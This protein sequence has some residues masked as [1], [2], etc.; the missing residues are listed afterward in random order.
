[1][2]MFRGLLPETPDEVLRLVLEDRY[3]WVRFTDILASPDALEPVRAALRDPR[4]GGL[5]ERNQRAV[6]EALEAQALAGRIEAVDELAAVPAART[7]FLRALTRCPSPAADARALAFLYQD[8]GAAEFLFRYFFHDSMP[9]QP[10]LRQG[11]RTPGPELRQRLSKCLREQ[12]AGE[13]GT[14]RLFLE[15][16]ADLALT[17][18]PPAPLPYP[19]PHFG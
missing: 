1:M 15:E 9:F 12:A 2:E 18:E 3:G 19:P 5:S 4:F 17:E 10:P 16:W 14:R 11:A 13:S 7:N 6:F 8:P